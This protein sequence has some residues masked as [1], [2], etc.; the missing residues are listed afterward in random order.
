MQASEGLFA[1]PRLPLRQLLG[2]MLHL[3]HLPPQWLATMEPA[4]EQPVP[5]EVQVVRAVR[6][7]VMLL[8]GQPPLAPPALAQVA[9]QE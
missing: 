9:Q 7:Q 3:L 1:G 6:E 4:L 5:L 2:E 8:A